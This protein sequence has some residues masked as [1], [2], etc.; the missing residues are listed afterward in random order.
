VLNKA[1]A[2]RRKDKKM[3][4]KHTPGP[5]KV[6]PYVANSGKYNKCRDVGPSGI[7]VAQVIGAFEQPTPGEECEANARLIAAAP[8][9]LEALILARDMLITALEADD[10][11]AC[12]QMEW[13][14][15]ELNQI[16]A[17]IAKAQDK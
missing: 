17:A 14:E 2:N 13:P 15:S 7:A 12:T 6:H 11:A 1:Y 3:E 8:D 4:S 9:M 5:W 16:N 10:P